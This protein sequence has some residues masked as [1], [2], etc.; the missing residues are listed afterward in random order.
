MRRLQVW[1][2]FTGSQVHLPNADFD[3][4]EGKSWSNQ[5]FPIRRATYTTKD[6]VADK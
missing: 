6:F 2:K 3:R 4:N 1:G 5:R